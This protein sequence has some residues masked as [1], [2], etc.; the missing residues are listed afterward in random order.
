[1]DRLTQ[2]TVFAAVVRTGSFT[3]AARD[4]GIAKST[5][6]RHVHDLEER[7]GTRLLH[8]TT[9]QLRTTD[10]GEAF[11]ER[12]AAIISDAEEAERVV[13]DRGDAPQGTLRIATQSY[14]AGAYLARP[15]AEFLALHPEV[16]VELGVDERFVDIVE[17]GWDMA[18]RISSMPDSSLIARKL[19]PSRMLF[20]AAPSYLEAHGTPTDPGQLSNHHL[21]TRIHPTRGESFRFQR[22]D[23][24]HVYK[25]KQ[26]RVR[27]N[28]GDALLPLVAEGAGIAMAPDFLAKPMLESGR[29]V[30]VLDAFAPD[31]GTWVYALYPHRRLVAAR[32]RAFLDHLVASFTPV[33]PWACGPDRV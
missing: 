1:M 14:F 30:T 26:P 15:I 31:D 10:I 13:T 11:Y 7:L 20:V 19:G 2:M 6:S 21:L 9:R 22:P 4:L 17:E 27:A 24:P 5:V 16:D 25:P 28:H 32:V 8:R 12:A 23:G 18:I 29:L 3:G 33:P